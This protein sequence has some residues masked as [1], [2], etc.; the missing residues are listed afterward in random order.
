MLCYFSVSVNRENLELLVQMIITAKAASGEGP[1][2]RRG[3]IALDAPSRPAHVFRLPLL[4]TFVCKIRTDFCCCSF[5]VKQNEEIKIQIENLWTQAPTWMNPED[6]V[7]SEV[8]RS[9]KGKYGRVPLIC[10]I[11]T[12]LF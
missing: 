1:G 6:M 7:Q 12:L 9:R 5:K 11:N 8:S 10:I 3:P 2:S 4:S